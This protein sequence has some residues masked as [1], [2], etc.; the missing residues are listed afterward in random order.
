MLYW[1]QRVP[2]PVS[3]VQ[4]SSV[5]QSCLTL[6]DP[7]NRSTPSLPVHDQL[8]EFTQTHVPRVSDA[9]Q[10][11][12]PRSS[13]SPPAPNPF[14]HWSL[15]Q[16]VNSSHEVAKALSPLT[17]LKM[18]PFRNLVWVIYSLSSIPC[19]H[20]GECASSVSFSSAC[21]LT[22]YLKQVILNICNTLYVI[23]YNKV[24]NITT[25]KKIYFS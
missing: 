23:H 9:I 13:P 18:F 2:S 14:Q 7:M 15:F 5:A 22:V 1:K 3:S 19:Y 10:P 4:F 21:A 24:Y 17:L 20:L 25:Q 16:W 12:H 8:L 11:S 6:C